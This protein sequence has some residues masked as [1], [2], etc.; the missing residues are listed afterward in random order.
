MLTMMMIMIGALLPPLSHQLGHHQ[1]TQMH[2]W[3]V[4]NKL[5]DNM[6]SIL[7]V[8]GVYLKLMQLL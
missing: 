7:F 6:K 3:L 1:N 5:L 2:R 8:M 4:I